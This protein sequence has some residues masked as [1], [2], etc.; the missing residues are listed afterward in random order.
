MDRRPIPPPKPNKFRVNSILQLIKKLPVNMKYEVKRIHVIL[1]SEEENEYVIS[2]IGTMLPA[3][4]IG[5]I[6]RWSSYVLLPTH[7]QKVLVN[8][9]C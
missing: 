6:G 7:V 4:K 8:R 5:L 1:Y 3:I 2:T 9:I